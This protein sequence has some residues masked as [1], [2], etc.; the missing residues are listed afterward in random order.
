M[1]PAGWRAFLFER[2]DVGSAAVDGALAGDG[3]ELDDNKACGFAK[4]FLR[5]C[6]MIGR[7]VVVRQRVAEFVALAAVGINK[8]ALAF[9]FDND[10]GLVEQ[11]E[12]VM[13]G[14]N[15]IGFEADFF[16]PF[17]EGGNKGH[18]ILHVM[19]QL[20]RMYTCRTMK[21]KDLCTLNLRAVAVAA[22]MW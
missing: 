20:E 12:P 11:A 16:L 9:N 14:E 3:I 7:H 8:P 13:L 2:F 1:R 15:A 19:G 4:A 6:G 18:R 21:A 22:R 5:D 17:Q 10:P